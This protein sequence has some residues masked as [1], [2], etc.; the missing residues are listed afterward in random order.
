MNRSEVVFVRHGDL[1]VS[2]VEVSQTISF[3][4]LHSF[5]GTLDNV[6][7]RVTYLSPLKDVILH[8]ENSVIQD[9]KRSAQPFL[10]LIEQPEERRA[11][12]L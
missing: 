1:T 10:S 8:L 4:P 2:V 5:P 11:V 12:P 9:I 6:R 7:L 3:F